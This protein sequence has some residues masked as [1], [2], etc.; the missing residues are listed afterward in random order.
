MRCE[1]QIS[2]C[3]DDGKSQT[4]LNISALIRMTALENILERLQLA[5]SGTSYCHFA[6][7]EAAT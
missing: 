7:Q 1:A 4:L 5:L 6:R 3:A 2:M